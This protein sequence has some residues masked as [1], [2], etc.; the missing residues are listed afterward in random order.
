MNPVREIE[1]KTSEGSIVEEKF[2]KFRRKSLPD[3]LLDSVPSSILYVGSDLI[4]H[5]VNN[6]YAK[7]FGV[8]TKDIVGL[9][10][11]E[12]PG[13]ET[14]DQIRPHIENALKG[15]TVQYEDKV[16][17]KH[18]DRFIK[19]RYTPDIDEL[20][21]VNGFI[22]VL[23]DVTE[24]KKASEGYERKES[25]FHGALA[26]SETHYRQLVRALPV[27]V[28]T[29]DKEGRITF[30]NEIAAEL[31]GY[32][33]DIT[34]DALKFCACYKVWMMDGTYV[35]PDKTPMAL[36]LKT[37]KSFRNVEAFVE[38]PNGE[39]FHAVVDIDPLFD[40][41]GN[42]NGAINI[43][44]DISNRKSVELALSESEYRYRGLIHSL[45]AAIYTTDKNGYITMYNEAAA[46]LWGRQPEI[47]KDQWCGSWKIFDLD[48]VT[49]I[50]LDKCPMAVALKERRK[51]VSSHPFLVER[52]DGTRR[53]FMP[54]PEPIF[55]V[56]GNLTGAFNMLVDVTEDR[57]A[58]T[59][60]AKLAA[61]VQSSD[62][63][64][65]GKTLDGIVTS[66]NAAAER[67]FGYTEEEMIGQSI[68][69]VIPRDRFD[70]EPQIL[71]RITKGER[72]DHFETKRISKYGK[73][74]DISLTI[75]PIRDSNG[76][77]VGASKIARNISAQKEAER[78]IHEND[79]RFR[80]AVETTNLGTWEFNPG[81]S[82]LFC[83]RESRKICGLPEDLSPDFDDIIKHI[84][85]EDKHYFLEQVSSALEPTGDGKFDMQVRIHRYDNRELCWIRAKGKIFFNS[86]H[87]PER[88]IGTMLNINEEKLK[89]QELRE[90]VEL[91]QTMAD[92]V[93]A[94]IWM[95]G[96][97]KFDDYFNKT[98]L[99]F[100]GKTI[101]QEKDEGWLEGVHPEDVKRCIDIYNNCFKDQKGVYIEYR[102]RR[103]DGVYRWISDNSIPRFSSEGEFL[104]FISACIDIDDQK[105]FREKIQ[106]SELLFKTISNASPAALWMTNEYEENIFISDTWLKWTGKNFDEVINRGW[107]QSVLEEDKETMVE[108]F[109][110]CFRNRKY[111]NAEFRFLKSNGELRWGLTEGYPFYDFN[112]SFAGYAGSV[113]DITE[114]KK[115]EQRKDDFIK[116]ASHEL[117]TPITSINGYVQLLLNIFNEADEQRIRLSKSTVKSSLNTIAKQV[118]KLT[119]LISELLDLSRIESG[120]LELQATSINLAELVEEIVQDVR[121][122]ASK[123]AILVHNDFEGKVLADKDRLAQVLLNL[124]TNAIKYSPDSDK[125]EVYVE[126]NKESAI[127][128]IKDYGI[129]IEKK[130]HNRIFE[131]FYRVEGKR[132]QTFPGFGIGLFIANEIMQRHGGTIRV[133]SEKGTGSVFIFSL[134]VI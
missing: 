54:H 16:H 62:D 112:R 46:R 3:I 69:K 99:E 47:G 98:W 40:D 107:I 111:F 114:I 28:Y 35:P 38:R 31:W 90:S 15:E 87:L 51:V 57:V 27:A 56:H 97:D 119:R 17:Y 58:E 80:M 102:L 130:D 49:E 78:I 134:P 4:Y 88:I 76:R 121:Q 21:N 72:V 74:L 124:L 63:A 123:H 127:V 64:I 84:Y 71:A 105:R 93:P 39:K 1:I 59:E 48:G 10:I 116:M 52:P 53:Y 70:E 91:F 92:N 103:K 79:E 32:R 41:S 125:I 34:D 126:K 36:A 95:S 18:G 25:E 115:L 68:T 67:L 117:K 129:G 61:I 133:E 43:F 132:E 108:E 131:R 66:W 20:G 37:G 73:L 110:E 19:A 120:K 83:S 94:M 13:K 86:E 9:S 85:R 100:T 128:K 81:E 8:E 14:Y 24:E 60:K 75:S 7:W 89:E 33:P 109:R 44:Q 77:V 30:F 6:T 29:C 55:D 65:V 106:E 42:L 23:N 82:K 101:E 104:G 113:T 45:P 5:Y 22:A 122:T 50:P 118:V 12:F 96:T 26:R 11:A 2:S